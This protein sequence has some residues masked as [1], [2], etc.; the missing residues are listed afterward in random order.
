MTSTNAFVDD[1]SEPCSTLAPST[2]PDVS[3]ENESSRN[4]ADDHQSDQEKS[5]EKSNP[6]DAIDESEYPTGARLGAI[7]A[8]LS[9]AIFLVSLDLTIVA[10]AIPK[11]TDEFNG[12]GDVSWYR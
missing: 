9:L 10:T 2:S 11:I 12:L 3:G 5:L 6:E 4:M 7:I 1:K 8:A